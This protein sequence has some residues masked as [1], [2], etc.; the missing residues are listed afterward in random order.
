MTAL[1][2][3][4]PHSL[5]RYKY[6]RNAIY[7]VD[8]CECGTVLYKV[9]DDQEKRQYRKELQHW[10]EQYEELPIDDVTIETGGIY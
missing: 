2:I 9:R 4:E 5:W 1:T 6:N 3:P 10:L 7:E 8:S